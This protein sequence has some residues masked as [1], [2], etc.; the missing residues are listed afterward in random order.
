MDEIR[1]KALTMAID[2]Y[3]EQD[4]TPEQL[5]VAAEAFEKFLRGK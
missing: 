1:E 4:V 5:V 2:A 3:K